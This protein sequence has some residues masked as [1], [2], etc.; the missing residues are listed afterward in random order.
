VLGTERAALEEAARPQDRRERFGVDRRAG[1]AR[2]GP[3]QFRAAD[4]DPSG[5]RPDRYR[6]ALTQERTR[7]IHRLQNLL[8]DAGIKL[9]CVVSDITGMSA[10]RMLSA[11]IHG[12]PATRGS[13]SD[14]SWSV[15]VE[16]VGAGPG[17]GKRDS[18][19]GA[20]CMPDGTIARS[21]FG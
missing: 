3:A 7:E 12:E 21:V 17:P 10:R 16:D 14:L 5:A 11:L 9:D 20:A 19:T 15:A 4:A 8:E 2:A 1:C 13:G 6:T 18:G